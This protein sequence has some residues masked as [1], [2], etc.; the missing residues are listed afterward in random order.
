MRTSAM[1]ANK[2]VDSG[3][4]KPKLDKLDFDKLAPVPVHLSKL[5]DVAKNDAIK[6]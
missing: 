4:L 5:S 6:K 3:I 1:R 2:F